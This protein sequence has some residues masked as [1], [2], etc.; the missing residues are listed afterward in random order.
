M[1]R[2]RR[3]SLG[4]SA[5]TSCERCR[6]RKIKCD[7][8]E[9]CSKCEKF[10][11]KCI[12]QGTGEKQ[13]P[14]RKG[15]VQALEG[16]V[17]S[18][19]LLL[20]KLAAADSKQRDELLAEFSVISGDVNSSPTQPPEDNA[21]NNGDLALARTRAGQMKKLRA[22]NASQ[23]FGGTSL[24]Q[25]HQSVGPP[26]SLPGLDFNALPA[27]ESLNSDASAASGH[28]STSRFQ[29]GPRDAI[30]RRLLATFFK[31]Q[32]Y[33]NMCI[34]REY[35]LRDYHAGTG[36]YYSE[37]LLYAICA[38]GALACEDS[39]LRELSV[40]FSSHA[41]TLL[42]ASLDNPD[43]T[44]LQALVLLGQCEIGYGKAS[45]GWLFC[46]MAFRLTHEMGLHL[47]P[48][49]WNDATQPSVDMEV[50]RR[51][52]W[53]TFIADKQL[54][55]Y[56]GRPPALYPHESDVRS[57]IR[58][59]YPPEWEGLL[60][61]YIG[62]GLSSAAF[63]DGIALIGS[64]TYQVELCKIL[65][66]IIT[67]LFENRRVNANTNTAVIATTAQQIH[68]SLT[69]WLGGLPAKLHWNQWTVG[70]VPAYVLHLHM[71]F[72]TAMIVLHRPPR[73]YFVMPGIATSEDVEICYESLYALV[74]LCR[75]YSRYYHYSSLPLDFVHTLSTAAGTILM[76]QFFEKATFDHPEI[77][78]SLGVIL[79]AMDEVKE[80]WPCMKEIQDSVLEAMKSRASGIPQTDPMLSL[81]LGTSLSAG[82]ELPTTG[83]GQ[84][85]GEAG[86]GSLATDLL[87]D[88]DWTVQF[89]GFPWDDQL[90]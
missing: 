56:F 67:N 39:R 7:R 48:Y 58:L 47:D 87:V 89:P 45:K 72:H 43:L 59:P 25:G 3:T 51:V 24:F 82:L 85:N 88:D 29:Y 8:Q 11:A 70:K 66:S 65:H 64:L 1:E 80:T 61:T 30:P 63:E 17:A 54:S 68:V 22:N 10:G 23:F 90:V 74:R 21:V 42:F 75:S 84:S 38:M 76:K 12:F 71:L 16:H 20:Q 31:E 34:Y 33:Y 32:Y 53:A 55:L 40:I 5:N 73:H 18:L 15:H 50:L 27:P 46:G 37:V 6:R 13:R 14:V 2:S 62:K 81:D 4:D 9:P 79:R 77:S 49:N 69:T 78:T 36:R 52:Y 41:E 28:S 19:E 26:A 83:A 44:T 57:T 86:F 60:G 35:F